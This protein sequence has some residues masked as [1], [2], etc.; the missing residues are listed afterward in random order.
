M[1]RWGFSWIA[2]A[3][4]LG[5]LGIALAAETVV[6]IGLDL[7]GLGWRELTFKG[8]TPNRFRGHEDGRL[9]VLTAQSVS[10][11]YHLIRV[12]PVLT[13][14]LAWRWRVDRAMEPTDLTRK[15]GDDR[16]VAVYV[17]FP[18][19]A[20]SSSPGERLKRF[21]VEQVEGPD[22]PGRVLIYVW[23]GRDA[24]GDSFAS[25][26][27]GASGAMRILRPGD[28]PLGTWQEERVDIAVD[29]RRAFGAAPPP[30]QYVAV[31]GDSDDTGS[32]SAATVAGLSFRPA[33]D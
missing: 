24:R 23:G 3:W 13:P 5:W 14:C 21:L 28:A 32:A 15:G 22:A 25:P 7:A 4:A 9:E 6:P 12:D 18:Y 10:L 27:M 31:A 2:L 20:S 11:L 16:P 19:V 33:C 30:T 26:H 8:K 1:T 29:Y 17:A